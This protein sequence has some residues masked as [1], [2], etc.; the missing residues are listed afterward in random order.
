MVAAAVS[1]AVQVAMVVWVV[2]WEERVAWA[3][4]T[5]EQEVTVAI[6]QHR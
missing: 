4:R 1:P 6:D 2:V 5:E 3:E